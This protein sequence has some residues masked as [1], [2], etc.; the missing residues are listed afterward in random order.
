MIFRISFAEFMKIN[1]F[2]G[3][4]NKILDAKYEQIWKNFW[5]PIFNSP[6]RSFKKYTPEIALYEI[7]NFHLFYWTMNSAPWGFKYIGI[8]KLEFE[9]TFQFPCFHW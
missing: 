9:A 1:V 5:S 6:P 8:R 3:K 2:R 7:L 4:K